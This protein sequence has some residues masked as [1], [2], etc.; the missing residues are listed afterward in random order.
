MS[1][2]S[3][4]Q[5][6]KMKTIRKSSEKGDKKGQHDLTRPDSELRRL[7]RLEPGQISHLFIS[8]LQAR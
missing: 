3:A 7:R 2:K 1:T 6:T 5:E 4:Q 8:L